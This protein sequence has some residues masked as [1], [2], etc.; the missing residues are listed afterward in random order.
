MD[1]SLL[2]SNLKDFATFGTNVEGLAEFSGFLVKLTSF[3]YG[4]GIDDSV[5]AFKGLSS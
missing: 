4:E 2:I 1:L 3:N 5:E